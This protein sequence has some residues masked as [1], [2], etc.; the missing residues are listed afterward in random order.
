ML[1][2]IDQ[3]FKY[4][5]QC[6]APAPAE[7]HT[8]RFLCSACGFCFYYNPACAVAGIIHDETRRVLFI[9]RR[10]DPSKGK[11]SLPGGFVDPGDSAEDALKREVK[12]EVNLEMVKSRF[13]CSAPNLYHYR[14]LSYTVTD[15]FFTAKIQS[16]DAI[17]PQAA[18]VEDILFL[19]IT[20]E[21][22]AQ[23][24]FPSL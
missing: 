11:L 13:L 5:P 3:A 1:Q 2:P 21:T 14:G 7:R 16:F 20:S 4:C 17:Q 12:E 15:F 24:A 10:K 6:A 23:L 22:V 8:C 18:E 19:T 9:R